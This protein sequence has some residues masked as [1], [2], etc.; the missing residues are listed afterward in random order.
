MDYKFLVTFIPANIRPVIFDTLESAKES[1]LLSYSRTQEGFLSFVREN[2]H[3]TKV[4][5]TNE[6]ATENIGEI[7]QLEYFTTIVHL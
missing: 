4:F 3:T 1:W 5:F 7:N 2:E 6:K